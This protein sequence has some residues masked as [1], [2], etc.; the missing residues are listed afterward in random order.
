[1]PSP[2][3]GHRCCWRVP[4]ATARC[5][6]PPLLDATTKRCSMP[7][8]PFR[9]RG[10][11]ASGRNH[12]PRT[13]S[14]MPS[15]RRSVMPS[16]ANSGF[17]ANFA[18]EVEKG[19]LPLT[20]KG[21]SSQGVEQFGRS[22][23]FVFS[24]HY[25][26]SFLD[27]VHELN[28][29]ECVLSGLERFKPQHGSCHPLYASMILL[30]NVV[31]ILDLTDGDRGA[32]L[33]IVALDGGFIGRTPVDGDLLRH[34]VAADRFLEKAERR[35]LVS[36]LSEE[37]VNGLAVLIHRPIQIA[38]LAFDFNRGFVH[39]PADPHRALTPVECLFQQGTVFHD[40]ALERRV[41]NRAPTPLQ[42]FFDMPIA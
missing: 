37:K 2:S 16:C 24:L 6:S 17:V 25:H 26:L 29:N 15:G 27:H 23:A 41:V 42:Q 1:M 39:P 9:R 22:E 18:Q 21:L 5:R 38:P 36:L 34:A 31:E 20:V 8:M 32:V 28:P 12:R 11:L 19:Q 35:L 14:F 3:G 33:G 10:W 4:A 40:P 30:H 7:S 13:A